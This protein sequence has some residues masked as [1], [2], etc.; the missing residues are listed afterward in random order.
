MYIVHIDGDPL[1]KKKVSCFSL[2]SRKTFV[3]ESKQNEDGCIGAS[4]SAFMFSNFADRIYKPSV[5]K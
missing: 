4:S 1:T 3:A 2:L 5:P